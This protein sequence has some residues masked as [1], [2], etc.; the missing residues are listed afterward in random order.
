VHHSYVS[1]A[2]IRARAA[3]G[4]PVRSRIL[5]AVCSPIRNPLSRRWRFVTAALSYGVA[6]PLGHLAARSAHVSEAPVRWK[7]VKGP[8]FDNNL[9]T[10]EVLGSGIRMWWARGTVVGRDHEHPVLEVVAD[11]TL[12]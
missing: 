9:A 8:W 10:L 6:G 5:Q 2:R 11:L 1:E 7:L 3:A 4:R 12:D